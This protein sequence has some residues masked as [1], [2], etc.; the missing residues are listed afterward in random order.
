MNELQR[1]AYL[2]AMGVEVFYLKNPLLGARQSPSYNYPVEADP[3]LIAKPDS[4][5][6]K[7]GKRENLARSEAFAALRTGL[8]TSKST[9]SEP[10]I[11]LATEVKKPQQGSDIK[12]LKSTA[13]IEPAA[14]QSANQDGEELDDA[15]R[16]RLRYFKI[17]DSLAVLDEQP[18]DREDISAGV[19][20]ELLR[21]ILTA[22][23]VDWAMCDF[24]F[25][26]VQWPLETNLVNDE[27]PRSAALQM[28]DGFLA[29]RQSVDKFQ[30]LLVFASSFEGWIE[31]DAAKASKPYKMTVCSSLS[32]MLAYPLLKREVWQQ[33]KPLKALL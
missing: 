31:A 13:T 14:A 24:D 23:N 9:H 27:T 25:E 33:L 2:D 22:V 5:L 11:E 16:F 17:N 18:F 3:Q 15:F 28:L 1:K 29:Q 6:V 12:E 21:N 10:K 8:T 32:A 19:S 26:T 4:A 20:V 7:P 30:H